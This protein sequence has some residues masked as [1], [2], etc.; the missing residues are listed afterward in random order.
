VIQKGWDWLTTPHPGFKMETQCSMGLDCSGAYMNKYN[1]QVNQPGS[2]Q[3]NGESSGEQ[4]EGYASVRDPKNA[5][6][7]R[8]SHLGKRKKFWKPIKRKM[9]VKSDPIKVVSV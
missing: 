3:G 2:Q 9:V 6:S 7:G 4:Q 5:G 8:N 1:N